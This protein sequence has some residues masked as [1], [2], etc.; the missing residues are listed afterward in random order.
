VGRCYIRDKAHIPAIVST[1]LSLLFALLVI[2]DIVVDPRA[3]QV[4]LFWMV[5]GLERPDGVPG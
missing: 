2:G 3:T 4:V 5:A 1:A